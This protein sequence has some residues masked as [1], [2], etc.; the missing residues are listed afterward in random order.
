MSIKELCDA[1]GCR[2]EFRAEKDDFVVCFYR[3]LRETW[4]GNQ[5]VTLQENL[6]QELDSILRTIDADYDILANILEYCQ[7]P[8]STKEILEHLHKSD[9][10]NL[11]T[12]YLRPLLDLKLLCLT[13]SDNPS[14]KKQKY[15][16]TEKYKRY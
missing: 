11:Q 7:E 4:N 16:T 2:V 14:S 15:V 12:K 13:E 9:R 3:N 1:V 10:G 6:Q 8:H 5:Q